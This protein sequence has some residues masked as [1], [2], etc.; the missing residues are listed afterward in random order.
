[1]IH[2]CA[3]LSKGWV[4]PRGGRGTR[5]GCGMATMDMHFLKSTL[6]GSLQPPIRPFSYNY[7]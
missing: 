5:V 1:M 2:G 4:G 3:F 7:Y 6:A